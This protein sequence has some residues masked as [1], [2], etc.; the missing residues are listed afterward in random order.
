[1]P[2]RPMSATVKKFGITSDTGGK[3]S[4]PQAERANGV[5]NHRTGS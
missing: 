3:A 1:M 4:Q 5:R 2:T